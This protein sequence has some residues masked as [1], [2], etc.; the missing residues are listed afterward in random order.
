MSPLMSAICLDCS[1]FAS[2][3]VSWTPCLAASSCMLAVSARRQG[4][5][6]AFWLKATLRPDVLVSLGAWSAVGTPEGG[7]ELPGSAAS[8]S[9][10]AAPPEDPP[11]AGALELPL[12]P[13]Q[14]ASRLTDS[15][16]TPTSGAIF[17][18]Y[19]KPSIG[20][21]PGARPGPVAGV[22]SMAISA[23]PVTAPGH[24]TVDHVT[25]YRWVQR[26]TPE[27]ID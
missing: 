23:A 24:I 6:L 9:G 14:P 18:R 15:T 12:L 8:T 27:L 26:F 4:L 13:P 3:T 25:I 1:L 16:V 10:H 20:C 22:M 7:S 21:V 17:F 5:L 19:T 2:V 11:P